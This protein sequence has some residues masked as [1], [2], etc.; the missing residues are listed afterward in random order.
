MSINPSEKVQI[1]IIITQTAT[2]RTEVFKT[3]GG[4]KKVQLSDR[5]ALVRDMIISQI[6][7]LDNPYDDDCVVVVRDPVQAIAGSSLSSRPSMGI[8]TTNNVAPDPVKC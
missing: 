6:E 4:K 5:T 1:C 3:G 8:S 7:P 2:H